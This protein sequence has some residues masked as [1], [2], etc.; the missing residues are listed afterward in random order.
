MN[1]HPR[2]EHA[3][4]P[5]DSNVAA[6]RAA[7]LRYTLDHGPG[8]R[9]RRAGRGWRFLDA[10]GTPLRDEE[11]L[12]RIRA[13]A[14]PPAWTD[15][16]INP[17]PCGHIQ[18]TGRDDRGRKQYIYHPCWQELRDETKFAN[19][20]YFAEALPRIRARVAD[21]L[22][23]PG[24]PR[25]RILAT[26]VRLLDESLIRVGND[27]YARANASFGL[28]TLRDEHVA[29]N[30]TLVRFVF[31]G[32]A[33]KMHEV[34]VRDRRVAPII[35]R[36]QDLPGQPLFQYL[37]DEGEPHSIDSGDVN[38]Y[39]AD[40]AGEGFTAKDFRTW[41]GTVLAARALR[42]LGP[43]AT[44]SATKA[45]IIAAID[46]VAQRLGNTRAVCRRAYIHP[47]IFAGYEAGDLVTF[48]T[49]RRASGLE[50]DEVWAL[51]YLSGSRRRGGEES[52]RNGNPQ[53]EAC[54]Q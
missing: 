34:D 18:A 22:G 39:L 26:V 30:G 45:N 9:R 16:W 36:L 3:T 43:A 54:H 29:V 35:R 5:P 46:T 13:L 42:D 47:A 1:G 31:R 27:E 11:A 49:R 12:R 4:S 10:E 21:D 44:K 33:S 17:D 40:A 32:K 38:E 6:A 19:L 8:I 14:I 15:V 53:P 41:A 20:V 2:A 24:L 25:E 37:D 23:R 52:R 51:A 28:T 50:C 7:G 48:K